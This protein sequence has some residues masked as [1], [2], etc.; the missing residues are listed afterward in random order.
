MQRR[1]FADSCIECSG[2]S[3]RCVRQTIKQ[4]EWNEENE[5]QTKVDE[6]LSAEMKQLMKEAE[7]TFS[8]SFDDNVSNLSNFAC[9]Q[10]VAA[11]FALADNRFILGKQLYHR[12]VL[13]H[14]LML[15]WYGTVLNKR[16]C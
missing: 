7:L 1:L 4:L 14:G 9:R 16:S 13:L 11:S 15:H 2:Y 5:G 6:R 3:N 12:C 10:D 8:K